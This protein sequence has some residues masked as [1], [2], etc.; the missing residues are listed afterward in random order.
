MQLLILFLLITGA[1]WG[2]YLVPRASL[3][4][5][6]ALYLIVA[7]TIGYDFWNFH[8]GISLSLD[9]L[10]LIGL[11]G[12]FGWHWLSRQTEPR[13]FATSELLLFG[14]LGLLLLNTFM[15][16][17]RR[18]TEDQVPIVQHL[19]EGY[20]IPT[21]LYW[22]ARRSIIRQQTLDIVYGMMIA[23]GVYLSL[24]A[25]CEITGQWSLV[26]P[27]HI[28]NPDIGI[29]F[30]RARGPFLQSIRMGIYLLICCFVT[31]TTLVWRGVWGQPGRLFG[32]LTFG[33]NV[34]AIG[35][36]LTRSIWLGLAG[37]G[38]IVAMLTFP[39]RLRRAVIVAAVLGA[40]VMIG[41]KGGGIVSIDREFGS[42]ETEESTNMRAVFA[43]VSYLMIK[44]KPISGFGFGHFPHK[45]ADYLND[46]ATN[47]DLESIRG[48]IH[49]NTFLSIFV[50]LGIGGFLLYASLLY[51]WTRQAWRLWKDVSVPD[52]MRG[53]GLIFILL[54]FA[55]AVQMLFH[56]ITYSPMENGLLFFM[57][58]IMSAIYS[59]NYCPVVK[60]IP[61]LD[62]LRRRYVS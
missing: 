56:D 58:G 40:V 50:E 2:C 14:Y 9:R 38:M 46:R 48:F 6:G 16:D 7:S 57:A 1:V 19:I 44:D 31:W 36:T 45:N 24:T 12:C 54:M 3:I 30:G 23:F 52:W 47:L 51:A 39:I 35:A 5:F 28:A 62:L 59:M 20:M 61:V 4:L 37:A 34:A 42:Q 17:W 43:Y 27:R 18:S 55:F 13:D 11:I 26:F 60:P 33:L 32:F 53:Q 41:F 10:L 21:I 22:I 15:H 49:H 29:H 8:A 25:M